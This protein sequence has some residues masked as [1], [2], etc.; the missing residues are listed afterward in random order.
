MDGCLKDLLTQIAI[1][2]TCEDSLLRGV[3][4]D[5]GIRC[6]TPTALGILGTLGDVGLAESC[7]ILLLV[8]PY[9]SIVG[10][11]GQQ[12]APLLLEVGDTEVDLLHTF[13]LVVRQQGTLAYKHLVDLL[14][15]LLVFTLQGIVLLVI[16]LTDTLEELFVEHDLIVEIGEQ[17]LHFF[18]YL[19]QFR[20]LISLYE[21]KE[22]TAHTVEHTST[23][24]IGKDGVLKRCGISILH[25]LLDIVTLLLDGSLEGRHIVSGLDLTEI[26]CTKWLSAL[27]HQGILTL[28]LLAGRE[29]HRCRGNGY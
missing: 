14:Q 22:H 18:L 21:G 2:E 4:D 17:G 16:D 5:D 15:Q 20:R 1:V 11:I 26:R 28:G 27:L 23:F 6:L 3:D 25:D 7:E 24:L 12:V 9:H 13:H 29:R 10:G 19:A 8:N